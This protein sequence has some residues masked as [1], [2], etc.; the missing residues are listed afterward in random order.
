MSIVTVT[1]RTVLPYLPNIQSHP[2]RNYGFRGFPHNGTMECVFFQSEPQAGG[3]PPR[4]GRVGL[5][6]HGRLHLQDLG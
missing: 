6:R 3:G 2:K 5:H 4:F 1:I